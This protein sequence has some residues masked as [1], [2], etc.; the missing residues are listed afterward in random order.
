MGRENIWQKIAN[1][2]GTKTALAATNQYVISV[3]ASVPGVSGEVVFGKS[4]IFGITA[5]TTPTSSFDSFSISSS[6]FASTIT[7]TVNYSGTNLSTVQIYVSCPSGISSPDGHGGDACNRTGSSFSGN[8]GSTRLQFNNSTGNSQQV[9]ITLSAYAATSN[10]FVGSKA[11][12]VTVPPSTNSQTQLTSIPV[13]IIDK[14]ITTI[15]G[16]RLLIYPSK[17]IN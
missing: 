7:S 2:F 4:N 10:V 12:Y 14:P 1:L 13:K 15:M 9:T 17:A 5:A 6:S 16:A 11:G 3:G 8:S